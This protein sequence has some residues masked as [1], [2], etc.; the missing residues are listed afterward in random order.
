M[1]QG[2]IDNGRLIV[3]VGFAPARPAKFVV[4]RVG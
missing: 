2:D 3:V 4:A 1:T